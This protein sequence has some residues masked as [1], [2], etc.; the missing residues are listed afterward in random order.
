[1]EQLSPHTGQLAPDLRRGRHRAHHIPGGDVQREPAGRVHD[2][3]RED[4][5]LAPLR[6]QFAVRTVSHGD[7]AELV[8][9]RSE[10]EGSLLRGPKEIL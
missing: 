10:S 6:G 5:Q 8:E 9:G 1:M 2:R 4:L 7:D 3:G